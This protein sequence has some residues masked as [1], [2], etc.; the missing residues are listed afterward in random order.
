V[1]V[2]RRL[3]APTREQLVAALTD[4]LDNAGSKAVKRGA[5]HWLGLIDAKPMGVVEAINRCDPREPGPMFV[6]W[7]ADAIG[8]THY[9]IHAGLGAPT[10]DARSKAAHHPLE[11]IAP[12]LTCGWRERQGKREFIVYCR[13]GVAGAPESVAWMGQSCGPCHDREQEGLKPLRPLTARPIVNPGEVLQSLS[14]GRFLVVNWES[15]FMHGEVAREVRYWLSVDEPGP[16]WTLEESGIG[17]SIVECGPFIVGCL[18]DNRYALIIDGA[19]G[20]TVERL[21][22]AGSPGHFNCGACVS[23]P[24][25][26]R[27]VLSQSHS[28]AWGQPLQDRLLAYDLGPG[29]WSGQPAWEAAGG[30]CPSMLSSPDGRQFLVLPYGGSVERRS[31]Q[32]GE[33][34]DEL[35]NAKGL[36]PHQPVFL[37]DGSVIAVLEDDS[38]V[39]GD[40]FLARWDAL[41]ATSRPMSFWDWLTGSIAS[42]QPAKIQHLP[43]SARLCTATPDGDIICVQAG[44][45]VVRCGKTLLPLS[46]LSLVG[47]E[48]TAWDHREFV[49]TPNGRLLV[50]TDQGLAVLPW[51]E[52]MGQP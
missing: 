16:L 43:V 39:R 29:G 25:G 19:T 27:L 22:F 2:P 5:E 30:P 49:F 20:R 44:A 6:A 48:V 15:S 35:G 10:L 9:F 7:W 32:S 46:S 41:D 50:N 21:S 3:V 14:D 23:G 37:P 12:P 24:V 18:A 51:H 45:L 26:S 8:R 17:E 33:A 40:R 1:S 28:D 34:I 47:A 42:S 36:G 31:A 13:C 4:A 38:G 52:L 11:W